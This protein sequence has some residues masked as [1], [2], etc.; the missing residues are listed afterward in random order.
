VNAAANRRN[1][2]CGAQA[3][4]GSVLVIA[5]MV[6]MGVAMLTACLLQFSVSTTRNQLHGIDKK[7]AFYLAEAGLSEAVYGL[8]IGRSGNVGAATAPAKFGDGLLW[9]DATE[10][11]DGRIFLNSNGL[12]GGGRAALSIVVERSEE[13]IS[14]LGVFSDGDLTVSKGS[15][16]DSYDSAN[17][18]PI[19]VLGGILLP[20]V[21]ARVGS[22][23]NI[24]VQGGESGSA[25]RINGDVTPGPQGTVTSGVGVTITGSTAPRT[26]VVQLPAIEVPAL[27]SL[28]DLNQVAARPLN[29]AAGQHRYDS[30]TVGAQSE[31]VILGPQTLVVGS[32]VVSTGAKLTI[33]ATAG[34]VRI[35]VTDFLNLATGSNVDSKLQDPTQVSLIVSASQTIDRNGDGVAELPASIMASGKLYGTIYAPDASITLVK[36]F[37]LYGAITAANLVLSENAKVHYDLALLTAASAG[38]EIR[39]LLSWRVMEL[40]ETP[41]V[42]LRVDPVEALKLQ[43]VAILAPAAAQQTTLFRIDYLDLRGKK[44]SWRGEEAKFDWQKVLLVLRIRRLGDADF[45]SRK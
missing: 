27:T 39:K 20:P 11:P 22:N 26:E 17:P 37:E 33:D 36:S 38:P 45:S 28:G 4:A 7:R 29:L 40:P 43:G 34:P 6:V 18:I 24:D 3:R 30:L 23:G 35:Y 41:L 13:P 25:T 15:E 16:I 10:S 32:M 14:A 8:M 19:P 2:R 44:K 12:C 42:S 5:L 9:V 31:L 21:P 1:G